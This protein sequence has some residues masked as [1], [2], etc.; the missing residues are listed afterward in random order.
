MDKFNPKA[1]QMGQ[2]KS[3][4]TQTKQKDTDVE[5]IKK[6]SRGGQRGEG[7]ERGQGAE[8]GGGMA[9]TECTVYA[10]KVVEEQAHFRSK[11]YLKPKEKH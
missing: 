1:T 8:G 9:H 4:G 10:F 11:I 5:E 2:L 6:G 3:R 7:N